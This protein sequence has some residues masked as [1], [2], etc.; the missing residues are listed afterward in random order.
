MQIHVLKGFNFFFFFFAQEYFESIDRYLSNSEKVASSREN[1]Y[2]FYSYYKSSTR[3]SSIQ[4]QLYFTNNLMNFYRLSIKTFKATKLFIDIT[5]Y[6]E[7]MKES[8]GYVQISIFLKLL[9]ET[10]FLKMLCSRSRNI[11][12]P[13]L[14]LYF[15]LKLPI[16]NV[17]FNDYYP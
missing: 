13:K 5:R 9:L 17:P 7:D 15:T 3:C 6:V 11:H 16:V 14:R 12:L 4:L 8:I 2:T 1:F 10:V